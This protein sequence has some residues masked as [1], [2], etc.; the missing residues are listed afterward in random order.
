MF[1]V[2]DDLIVEVVELKFGEVGNSDEELLVFVFGGEVLFV[3]LWCDLKV[4]LFEVV[5]EFFLDG[6]VEEEQQE[7]HA[8]QVVVL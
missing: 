5:S 7:V 3:V 1:V 2:A 6:G 4:G 8:S